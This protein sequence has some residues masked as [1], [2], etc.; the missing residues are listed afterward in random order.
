M[1]DNPT[2][3]SVW[4]RGSLVGGLH[5]IGEFSWFEL[6]EVYLS[7]PDREVLGLAF[8]D[9][10]TPVRAANLQLPPWFSNLLPEGRL[11]EWIAEEIDV[12]PHREMELL[13]RVG[14]D[15]PGAVQV[16]LGASNPGDPPPG[17]VAEARRSAEHDWRFS[18]AG[19]ALKLSM[20]EKGE[21]LSVPAT[22]E[23]GDWIVKLP[24]PQYKDVPRNEHAMM[25]LAHRCG[26]EV[27]EFKLVD[28]SQLGE[29]PAAAWQSTESV[30]YATRRFDRG[31][32]RQLIHVEDLAQV[33]GLYPR[34]KYDGTFETV[35]SLVYRG[36]DLDSLKE[37]V[38]RLTLNILIANGDAHLKNWSLIYDDPRRPRLSPAYDIVATEH[39]VSAVRD[40]D[41]GMTF[42]GSKRIDAITPGYFHALELRLGVKVR[43]L[44]RVAKETVEAAFYAWPEVSELLTCNDGLRATIDRS[45]QRRSVSLGLRS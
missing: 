36:S 38:R 32:Q 31:P 8:E 1:A 21:R 44:Q 6:D 7:N 35:A 23:G 22:G 27:P 13:S 43:E 28:Q 26:I 33:H 18:L 20:V 17:L 29:L 2:S 34:N 12:R 42:G 25:T 14:L 45:I 3:Y 40:E 15:L 16:T 41:L 19:V 9:D 24:D 10:P 37:F 39:Y 5:R 4:L 30:A 11:R